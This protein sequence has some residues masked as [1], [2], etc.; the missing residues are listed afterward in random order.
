MTMEQLG[1]FPT[2]VGAV[3]IVVVCYEAYVTVMA[4]RLGA[5][6]RFLV[7]RKMQDWWGFKWG[8][9]AS[10]VLDCLAM[11]VLLYGTTLGPAWIE[12]VSV[13]LAVVLTVWR[14]AVALD[15][16]EIYQRFKEGG[17]R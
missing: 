13:A 7:T 6:E 5:D 3:F 15:N 16:H 8:T 4:R 1:W 10:Y 12:A 17:K 11:G 2:A 14:G 9:I